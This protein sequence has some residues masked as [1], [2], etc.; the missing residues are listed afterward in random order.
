RLHG[1]RCRRAPLGQTHHFTAE[2]P[3]F[4]CLDGPEQGGRRESGRRRLIAGGGPRL[5]DSVT[6]NA[7]SRARANPPLPA[8]LGDRPA[9]SNTSSFM[10]AW[11]GFE[12]TTFG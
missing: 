3:L 8:V 5:L 7:G 12:Q 6:S 10:V 11:V 1:A 2:R 4:G 9:F